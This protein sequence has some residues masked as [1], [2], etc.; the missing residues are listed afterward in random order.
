MRF[1]VAMC[2]D[3]GSGVNLWRGSGYGFL[4]TMD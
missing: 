2:P 1:G 3:T 4:K